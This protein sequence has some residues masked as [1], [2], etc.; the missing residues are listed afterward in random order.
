MYCLVLSAN[1]HLN[2]IIDCKRLIGPEDIFGLR[3]MLNKF[4][5]VLKKFYATASNKNVK[6]ISYTN[7]FVLA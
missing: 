6:I 5:K 1:A 2:T 4:Y 7:V 3:G